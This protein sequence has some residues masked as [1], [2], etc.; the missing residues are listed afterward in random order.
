MSSRFIMP[1]QGV[2][3]QNLTPADGAKLFFKVIGQGIG[4]TNKTV[5]TDEALTTPATN[6]VIADSKGLFE[7]LWLNGDYDT[8]LTD[9]NDNQLWGPETIRDLISSSSRDSANEAT[10]STMVNNTAYTSASVGNTVIYRKEFSTG[11]GGEGVLDIVLTS[12]VTPNAQNINIGVADPLISFVLR[13]PYLS[14]Q[15]FGY[16]AT[17]TTWAE[18][19]EII[20]LISADGGGEFEIF[21][22]AGPTI[23]NSL[24]MKSNVKIICHDT[25]NITSAAGGDVISLDGISDAQWIGGSLISD[26]VSATQSCFILENSAT[27]NLIAPEF[28]TDFR[29]KG[30][31]IKTA[32]HHNVIWRPNVSGNTGSGVGVCISI[33]G[34]DDDKPNY[35]VIYEPHVHDARGGIA[36]QGGFYNKVIR[37]HCEDLTLWGVGMD[38][39]VS[40][41]GDGARHTYVESPTCIRVTSATFA[42]IYFG[43]GSSFNTVINPTCLDCVQGIRSSGG[44]G[45]EPKSNKILYPVIDGDTDTLAAGVTGIQIS[46]GDKTEIISPDVRNVTGRGLYLFTSQGSKVYGGEVQNCGGEGVYLQTKDCIISAVNSHDNNYG[47]R[48]EFGGDADGSNR[49][50]ECIGGNNTTSDFQRGIPSTHVHNCSGLINTNSGTGSITNGG[51]TDVI[52]HGLSYTPTAEDIRVT[53]TENPSNDPGNIWIST[54]TSTQ[55]TVNSRN[56]PGASNL[57]FSWAVTE[58]DL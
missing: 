9:K 25:I 8:F 18:I 40:D 7:E 53:L 1:R 27:K 24:A 51:T 10:T 23:V 12:S 37:P 21:K 19:Q 56:D 31:D 26:G 29:N 16:D 55:F 32:A 46:S 50:H 36:V 43:N 47:F 58:V 3:G 34:A 17:S 49:F 35:N 45:F 30:V 15:Q 39:V 14:A 48:I 33:F 57:N 22:T 11:N 54:I 42:G 28:I 20:D 2:K 52:T 44:V 5:F 41:S 13:K 4:G 38:G 6:P